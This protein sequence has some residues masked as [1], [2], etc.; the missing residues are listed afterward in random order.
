MTGIIM[1]AVL[2]FDLGMVF[3]AWWS[4]REREISGLVDKNP[5]SG[6]EWRPENDTKTRHNHSSSTRRLQVQNIEPG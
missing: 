2:A 4:E 5:R 3:M 6:V 1:T